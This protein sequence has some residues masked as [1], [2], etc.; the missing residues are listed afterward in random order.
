MGDFYD[1]FLTLNLRP[2]L[3]AAELA[4]LR[5]HLGLG[6]QPAELTIL[7]DFPEVVLDENGKAEVDD[8]GDWRVENAPRPVLARRGAAWRLGGALFSLLEPRTEGWA[9]TTRQELHPDEY[10]HVDRLLDWL[11]S[12]A[13][14]DFGCYAGYERFYEEDTIT[15]RLVIEDST[16]R[17]RE[18]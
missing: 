15:R 9:L 14:S 2:V 6:P 18:P 13:N 1:F 7:T 10:Q 11:G 17:R 12:R 8:N 4:E 5:W 16:I 3:S